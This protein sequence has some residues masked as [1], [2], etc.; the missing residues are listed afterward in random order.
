MKGEEWKKK[1]EDKEGRKVM[2][3]CPKLPI[4]TR[5]LTRVATTQVPPNSYKQATE[6]RQR[7]FIM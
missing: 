1:G 5:D 7:T 2:M 3:F 6:V 4:R